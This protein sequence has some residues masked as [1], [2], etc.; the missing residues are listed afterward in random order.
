MAILV[1]V[2]LGCKLFTMA[3]VAFPIV[4]P[5]AALCE[6]LPLPLPLWETLLLEGVKAFLQLYAT[7]H[8]LL[9]LKLQ[10][11]PVHQSNFFATL[12]VAVERDCLVVIELFGKNL[13][14]AW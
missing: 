7:W 2:H 14:N 11:W 9:V 3:S 10:V 6:A 4:A 1:Q 13:S 12:Y 8:V 5:A